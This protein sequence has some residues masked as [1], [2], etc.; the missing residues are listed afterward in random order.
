M[1]GSRDAQIAGGAPG[2]RWLPRRSVRLKRR[3][4]QALAEG[5]STPKIRVSVGHER[6]GRAGVS[7]L[8]RI[9][10]AGE[11]LGSTPVS[12]PEVKEF[13]ASV[14]QGSSLAV[15][16][17]L[18]GEPQPDRE[19]REAPRLASRPPA[20][21]L[22]PR[23]RSVMGC[24][25]A[26]PIMG[27]VPQVIRVAVHARLVTPGTPPKLRASVRVRAGPKAARLD[28]LL[29]L[30]STPVIR[31]PPT[32]RTYRPTNSDRVTPTDRA[33]CA[34]EFRPG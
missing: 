26:R 3:V 23:T 7:C 1:P 5:S 6:R 27:S 11:L 2:D 22:P 13:V 28:R 16:R 31:A 30:P 15:R 10:L 12:C 4:R 32:V 21:H 34:A 9:A 17:V 19:R 25:S 24:P 20:F 8:P 14:F 29:P 18:E 33:L